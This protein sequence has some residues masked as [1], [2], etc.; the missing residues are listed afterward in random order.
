MSNKIKKIIL[1]NDFL[2]AD[3]YPD[4]GGLCASIKLKKEL[5]EPRELLAWPD[6]FDPENYLKISGGLPLLFPIC[7]R[8]SREGKLGRYLYNHQIFNLNIHGF[9]YKNKFE[10]ILN[11]N[12]KIILR[13]QD[14][15]NTRAQYPFRFEIVLTYFLENKKLVCEQVYKNLDEKPMPF[16]AGFHPYFL[17]DKDRAG[18]TLSFQAQKSFIYNS[19]LTDVIGEQECLAM[20]IDLSDESKEGYNERLSL[21]GADKKIF[22]KL[23]DGLVLTQETNFNYLQLYTDFNKNFICLEPWMSHP[24]SFNSL[25]ANKILAPGESFTGVY[26]FGVE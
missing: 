19:Q 21:L 22:L 10:I 26:K 4:L 17:I 9:L 14:N 1:E 18:A 24:N 2:S 12:N 20:P 6:G 13:T 3:I 15:E 16:Y 23:K 11:K 25:L 7:G 5:E 8:L